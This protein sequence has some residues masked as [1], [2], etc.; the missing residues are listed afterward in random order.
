MPDKDLGNSGI[1]F[2]TFSGTVGDENGTLPP[3]LREVV[4]AWPALRA[5]TRAAIMA[6]IQGEGGDA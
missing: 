4:S 5:E 6:M 2:G 1:P 3:D